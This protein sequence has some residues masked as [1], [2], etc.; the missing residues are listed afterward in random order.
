M[1]YCIQSYLQS[2]DSRRDPRFRRRC[3]VAPA[4]IATRPQRSVSLR[5]NSALR[6]R[7]VAHRHAPPGA[8]LAFWR[9]AQL[10]IRHADDAIRAVQLW[11]DV[12]LRQRIGRYHTGV[13]ALRQP[14]GKLALQPADC[15]LSA[16]VPT[17]SFCAAFPLLPSSTT[18]RKY[19]NCLNSP[20][21]S[22]RPRKSRTTVGCTPPLSGDVAGRKSDREDLPSGTG[23]L[24]P[25]VPQDCPRRQR[26]IM[27]VP[28]V[29]LK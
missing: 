4:T 29:W 17:P 10:A 18:C 12:G 7:Q 22:H 11:A 6:G 2:A 3:A 27:T 8:G 14:R 26:M 15:W 19:R 1:Q 23:R 20:P 25:A 9:Q 21:P 16:H 5:M 13:R 28:P 24:P